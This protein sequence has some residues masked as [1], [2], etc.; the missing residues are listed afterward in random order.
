MVAA[1]PPERAGTGGA[2]AGDPG[3]ATLPRLFRRDGRRQVTYARACWER[4]SHRPARAASAGSRG[5]SLDPTVSAMQ[6]LMCLRRSS[7]GRST[8]R[9]RRGRPGHAKPGGRPAVLRKVAAWELVAAVC[10]LHH[11]LATLRD[12]EIV[13]FVD[14][15][16]R[17]GKGRRA[18]RAM[19]RWPRQAALGVLLRGTSRQADYNALVAD[20]WFAAATARCLLSA[21]YVPSALNVADAP[22][23]PATKAAAIAA[24]HRE[25][26]TRVAWPWPRAAPWHSRGHA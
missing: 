25:G 22:T 24:M 3:A 26:F 23:R 10:A 9:R 4:R 1:L 17:P 19:L 18:A 15:K 16:A 12:A 11:L 8:A 6:R 21:W 14:S 13:L 2:P 20:I 7:G 5:S